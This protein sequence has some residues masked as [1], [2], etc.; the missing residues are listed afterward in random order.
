M[1]VPLNIDWQ[2]ILLHLLNFVILF[3]ILYFL[4]YEPVKKFM[5]N[6]TQYYRNIDNEAKKNLQQAQDAKKEYAA[7]LRSA[8]AEIEKKRQAAYQEISESTAKSMLAA[9]QDAEN[10]ILDARKKAE[11]ERDKILK[12]AQSE[13]TEMVT[14]ATEKLVLQLGTSESYEQ[15]LAAAERGRE[16][17]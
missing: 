2:Q 13:I 7:K 9:K 11:S 3:A 5:D 16:N 15:F 10:I 14:D 6:R 17:G 8:D 12:N 4:L 1:N